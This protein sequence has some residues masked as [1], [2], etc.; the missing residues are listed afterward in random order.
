MA[1]GPQKLKILLDPF[2][3][4]DTCWLSSFVICDQSLWPFYNASVLSPSVANNLTYIYM[5]ATVRYDLIVSSIYIDLACWEHMFLLSL[6][7]GYT[8][9][10][11]IIYGIFVNIFC[12]RGLKH[13]VLKSTFPAGCLEELRLLKFAFHSLELRFSEFRIITVSSWR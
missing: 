12:M 13:S 5:E 1:R 11:Y 6:F 3:L 4:A 7:T 10:K 8:N 2:K 9:K